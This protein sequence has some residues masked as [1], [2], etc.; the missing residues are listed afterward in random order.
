MPDT[1]SILASRVCALVGRARAARLVPQSPIINFEA[2][3]RRA[4]SIDLVRSFSAFEAEQGKFGWR[5]GVH[6]EARENHRSATN[7]WRLECAYHLAEALHGISTVA[8][9]ESVT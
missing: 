4:C 1:D 5:R 8:G 9:T 2:Y 3:A 6:A 7:F